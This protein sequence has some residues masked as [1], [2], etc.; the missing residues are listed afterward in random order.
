MNPHARDLDFVVVLGIANRFASIVHAAGVVTMSVAPREVLVGAVK[1]R[2]RRRVA[3]LCLPP[4]RAPC[5][6]CSGCSAPFSLAPRGRPAV[7]C[8]IEPA[9]CRRP[10]HPTAV[11]PAH[12]RTL[13]GFHNRPRSILDGVMRAGSIHGHNPCCAYYYSSRYS[14]LVVPQYKITQYKV[15]FPEKPELVLPYTLLHY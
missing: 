7:C 8:A 3:A 10:V 14:V 6:V 12:R 4:Q 5:L 9:E 11:A 2:S 15:M 1:G 13:R